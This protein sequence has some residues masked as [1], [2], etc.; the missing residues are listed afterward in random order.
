MLRSRSVGSLGQ[1]R[2]RESAALELTF[3]AFDSVRAWAT[4]RLVGERP[5]DESPTLGRQLLGLG[6]IAGSF[7]FAFVIQSVFF[8]KSTWMLAD[9]AYHRGVAYT[10]QGAMFQGEGPYAGLISYYGGLYPLGLGLAA[11]ASH[12]TFDSVLSVASWF[13]TLLMPAA[14][15]L[16]GW[17]LWRN[18]LFAIGF[19]VTL[20]TLAVPF[21]TNWDELWVESVLPSGASYWPVYP[22]DIALAFACVALWALLSDSRRV[23]TIGLGL[24]VGLCLLFHAQMGILLAWFLILFA[25]WRAIRARSRE[26]LVE[27]GLAG[28]ISLAVTA[29]WWIPR[30]IAFAQSGTLLIADHASRLPFNP[31]PVELLIG[32]GCAGVLAL[33]AI[34]HFV[35]RRPGGTQAWIFLAWIA[36]FLPLIVLSRVNPALDL[37]TERR[38]WLVISLGAIGLATCG[39]VLVTKRT[40]VV[41]LAA[42]VIVTV[43]LPSIPGNQA[44][45][46]RVRNAVNVAWR[47][48]NAGMARQLEVEKWRLAMRQLNG[49]VRQQGRA[50]VVTYDAYG[51]WAWS[52]S[53]AQVISLWTPGPFKLGFRP[54]GA[55]R[56]GLSRARPSGRSGLR[57]R[58]GRYLRACR[59]RE[60]RRH[61]PATVSRTRRFVRPVVRLPVP[62]GSSGPGRRPHR[63]RGRTRRLV[64]GRQCAGRP[65]APAGNLAHDPVGRCGRVATRP[66]GRSR[67]FPRPRHHFGQDADSGGKDR[68]SPQG[69][70]RL[71]VRGHLGGRGW[72]NDHGARGG[73]RLRAHRLRTVDGFPPGRGRWAVRG[74]HRSTL[75]ASRRAVIEAVQTVAVLVAFFVV[76]GITWGPLIAPGT[77]PG[78]SRIG[79]TVGC[80]L[81]VTAVAMT[82]LAIVGVLRPVAVVP[83]LA[84]LSL[85]RSP[86]HRLVRKL[87]G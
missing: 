48:G 64:R 53:G 44:S 17:R 67:C 74:S 73:G 61:P 23:R 14:L 7:V 72:R 15:F 59:L 68:R 38:L 76:P 49:L 18:D 6:M 28:A 78:L 3:P 69:G 63:P 46:R 19:F 85:A 26:P 81:V 30:L 80:S 33:A 65:P 1:N 8:S 16:L 47:P 22:R 35:I 71:G 56:Q 24:I 84:V 52:F 70:A 9:L 13:G 12:R 75:R 2:A 45:V 43:A 82:A 54:E 39:I 83:T 87:P 20:G 42:L 41:V 40:P 32:Y 62:S 66:P 34:V 11:E 77:P 29:W 21:T 58:P 86:S 31:G 50:T 5:S 55:D 4:R 60:G 27:V 10:M 25:G 36:A 79:R 37:F 57:R 51:A